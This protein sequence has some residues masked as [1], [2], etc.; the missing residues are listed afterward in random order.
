M[1]PTPV[2]APLPIRQPPI[3]PAYVLRET[4]NFLALNKPCWVDPDLNGD[5]ASLGGRLRASRPTTAEQPSWTPLLSPLIAG[6]KTQSAQTA[7]SGVVL[8]GRGG[9]PPNGFAAAHEAGAVTCTWIVGVEG[10]PADTGHD[11]VAGRAALAGLGEG[12][13]IAGVT[14]VGTEAHSGRALLLLRARDGICVLETLGTLGWHA[15]GDPRRNDPGDTDRLILH[16]KE[17]MWPGTT[18]LAP[19]PDEV[20]AWLH[21]RAATLKNR[22]S[23]ALL[24]RHALGHDEHTDTFR[25]YDDEADMTLDLYRDDLVMS[26]Y[27]ALDGP[28]DDTARLERLLVTER[29]RG[30]Q[31]G[32][33]LGVRQVFLKL[34]PKQAN[35]V[36]DAIRGGLT[37]KEPIWTR[38][39]RHDGRIIVAEAGVRYWVQLDRGLGTGLYLDQRP[40]RIWLRGVADG[41]RVLN[42]FAY[43]C[44][45]SV[46]AAVGGARR[47]VSIDASGQAL[48]EGRMSLALND[49]NDPE[50]HDTIKGDVFRWLPRMARRGDRFDIVILDPPSYSRVQ[51]RRF[52]AEKDY[53]ELIETALMLLVEGGRLLAC[54]NHSRVD[55]RRLHQ[56]VLAGCQRAGRAIASIEHVPAAIDHPA[57]RMKSLIATVS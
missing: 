15:A 11:A 26:S 27:L 54:I 14:L 31:I 44:A 42:T 7:A 40:N 25:L 34:R 46:A 22:L 30:R 21:R 39:G 23:R 50:R 20:D 49:Q 2:N 43:T 17:V 9:S 5:A 3:P 33:L 8:L 51:K 28:G 1:R 24:R 13:R 12:L 16:R 48:D 47:T 41:L 32:E 6:R 37:P 36:V 4:P 57:G 52:S 10:W 45:F 38:D 53:A 19:V 18:L 55:R 29:Q 35:T 56:L